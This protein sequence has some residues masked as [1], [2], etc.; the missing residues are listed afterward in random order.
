MPRLSLA[1]LRVRLVLLVLF[2]LLPVFGLVI[3]GD[4]EQRQLTT[5]HAQDSALRLAR[6]AAA[7]QAQSIHAAH[8]LLLVLAR[9]PQARNHDAAACDLLF[10]NLLKQQAAY[11]NLA[12]ADLDGTVYCS[13]L[14][15]ASPVNIADRPYFQR[16]LQTRDFAIGEYQISRIADVPTLNTSLPVTDDAGKIQGVVIA[17][18]NLTWFNQLAAATQLPSGAAVTVIDRNGTILARY[19]EPEK[20]LGKTMPEASIMQAIA[21]QHDEGTAEGLGIDGVARL[22]AFVPIDDSATPPDAYVSVGIPSALAYAEVDQALTRNLIGLALVALLAF[23]AAWLFGEVFIARRTE[24]LAGVTQQW[25]A[26]NLSARS[27]L[28]GEGELDVLARRLDQMAAALQAREKERAEA[29]AAARQWADIFQSTQV[30]IIVGDPGDTSVIFNPA[31]AALH[32]YTMEELRNKP[33]TELLSVESRRDFTEQL[34]I[35]QATGHH[36]FES[37]GLRKDGTLFPALI[38]A[39]VVRDEHGNVISRVATVQDIGE[40]KRAE[41]AERDQRVLAEALHDTAA[42]LNSTLDFD[43]VLQRILDNVGR[44]VPHDAA[45]LMLVEGAVARAVASRGYAAHGAGAWL[46]A[47]RFPIA[48]FSR[49]RE[50]LATGRAH[51]IT[52]VRSYPAWVD[53]PE[54]R[55]IR[56][57]LGMPI[58]VRKRVI[59]FLNLS[60]TTPGYFGATHLA[61]LETFADQV[62]IA[63]EN[64]RLLAETEQRASQFGAL[65]EIARDLAAQRDVLTLLQ[66]IVD[67]AIGLLHARCGFIYLYDSARQ[68]LE[69]VVEKGFDFPIGL[70]LQIGE[71]MAGSVARDRQPLIVDDYRVWE[72]RSAQYAGA[73]YAAV[74]EVPM[75]DGGELIGVLGVAEIGKTTRTFTEADAQVLTLLAAH[76]A[77]AVHNASLHEETHARADQLAL[78]YDAGLALNSVLDS[79]VQLEYLLKIAMKALNADRAEFSRF[80]ATAGQLISDLNAGYDDDEKAAEARKR[81]RFSIDD[82]KGLVSQ[83][84]RQRASLRLN[85]VQSDPRWI[86]IDSE[87]RSAL[88]APVQHE[89]ALRGVLAVLSTRRN[90]F[91]PQDERLLVLFANQFAVAMENARLFDETR[92]RAERLAVLNRIA[93]AVSQTLDLDEL[94]QIIYLEIAAVLTVEAFFIAFYD[95]ASNE[96]DFRIQVDE[97]VREKPMRIPLKMGLSERVLTTKKPVLIRDRAAES[98]FPTAPLTLWGTMKH[99]VAWLGVPMLIGDHVI[100]IISVQA[101]RPNVYGEEEERLLATIADQVAVAV[102][103][104]RLF[105]ETRRR[106]IELEAVNRISTALRIAQTIDEIMPLLLDELLAVLD[107]PAGQVALHDAPS[108][109]L[110]VAVARGWFAETPPVAPA[111]DG[112]AGLALKTGEPYVTREFATDRSTSELARAKIPPGWGGTI[113]PIRTAQEIIGV[114]AVAVKLPRELTA[115]EIRLLATLSEI[116]GNAIHRVALHEQTEER[117]RRLDALHLIDTAIGA[118]MDLRVTLNVLLDQV[119]TQ[120]RVDAADVLL[121]NPHTQ[122][123]EY[124]AGR[125]F[126]TAVIERSRVRMGQDFAGRAPLERRLIQITNLIEAGA[127]TPYAELIAGEG[128]VVYFAAPLI[129]KGEI[130]G[131]LEIFHRTPFAPDSEWLDFIGTLAGQAALA[132]DNAAMFD[133]LQR[134]NFDISLAYDATIEG[135]ARALE[136][137]DPESYGKTERVTEMTLTLARALGIGDEEIVHLRR[138]AL[139]HDIGKM[140]IPDHLLRKGD[141]LTAAE[142]E[143]M[144]QHPAIASQLLLPIAYLRPAIDI[145]YC[146]HE[147][148]DGRGYPRGLQGE[149]I[150]LSAR[151]F[152]VVDAWD[153]LSS[154]QPGRPALAFA[155]AQQQ[156]REQAGKSLDPAVVEVLLRLRRETN[157]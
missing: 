35:A 118:S 114:F 106:L 91:T 142:E 13:A 45:D 77:S 34:A 4:I 155:Q 104:A 42:A 130:Q 138:G 151:L 145:P 129:A 30:G 124:A 39:T 95:A 55:W 1:S 10:A 100:G 23:V 120:L 9:L 11:S 3:Y 127:A 83:V 63:L 33:I 67:R 139:L 61:R 107:T 108:G 76:G 126:R 115:G 64:A 78:L 25:S 89:N 60:S 149:Q 19:P 47:Q 90:A 53:L 41:A 8:Q 148:W 5:H 82:E 24:A 131:V 46:M 119:V 121:L 140:G 112:I 20:W 152:A 22:Y 59:G 31:F 102:Q 49:M 128:F 38:D 2:A 32:G 21:T 122:V 62:A 16:T 135:W 80:D 69:L 98:Q 51:L 125:G 56:S 54:T 66:T 84:A 88:W 157:G 52:D 110:R 50:M 141:A 92:R 146:H 111:D 40:L 26:G 97:G 96:L 15:L 29:D 116:A 136:L 57:L 103:T 147:R 37:Q 144:R 117:L 132:I 94:L 86:V 71:G 65:Y 134:S 85:D 153:D 109:E 81:L 27:K 43:E 6:I 28:R 137:R 74:V 87:I 133:G 150:P 123:L 101:Y 17:A 14:P 44:V 48:R 79:K 68:D 154:D 143:I 58:R 75:L 72:Q 113:V 99:A 93:R 7:S 12:V 70:R 105:D 18:L 156:L 36:I 73:D